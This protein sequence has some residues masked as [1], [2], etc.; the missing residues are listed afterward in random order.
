MNLKGE[1]I[2]RNAL[3]VRSDFEEVQECQRIVGNKIK[4][5]LCAT[6]N[7]DYNAL[8]SNAMSLVQMPV[9][10]VIDGGQR[11]QEVGKKGAWHLA[12]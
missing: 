5:S 1:G 12:L 2:R 4:R 3:W 9:G 6:T 7:T 8:A 10:G 11:K